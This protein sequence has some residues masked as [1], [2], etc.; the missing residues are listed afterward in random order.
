M[1]IFKEFEFDSAHWLP[2]VIPGHK[3]GRMH[4]HTYR[5]RVEARGVVGAAGMVIDFGIIKAAFETLKGL[6]D[7]H[8]L[9][10]VPG[11]E[12]STVENLARWIFERLDA[13]L[14]PHVRLHAVEVRETPTAGARVERS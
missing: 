7:H 6:L 3:C 14:P 4:G 13:L 10:E 11:L 8:V 9:N 5:A 12:N 2:L 1:T